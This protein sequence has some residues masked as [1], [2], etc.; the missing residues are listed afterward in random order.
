MKTSILQVRAH[1]N[2]LYGWNNGMSPESKQIWNEFWRGKANARLREWDVVEHRDYFNIVQKISGTSVYLHPMNFDFFIKGSGGVS[3][4]GISE[5]AR[6][7]YELNELC[8]EIA[9][10]LGGTFSLFTK[11]VEMEHYF[12]NEMEKYIPAS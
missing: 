4:N 1:F 12:E 6:A 5:S 2:G 9:T 8:T 10:K 7:I 11:S 3:V